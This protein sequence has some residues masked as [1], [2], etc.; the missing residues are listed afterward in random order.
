MFFGTIVAP[1]LTQIFVV[2]LPVRSLPV[3]FLT[4]AVAIPYRLTFGT[5]VRR[6]GFATVET[7]SLFSVHAYDLF[8]Q[9][10][11]KVFIEWHGG[12]DLI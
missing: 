11:I 4:V 3:S 5:A 10:F 9:V 12:F 8:A 2:C 6:S 1:Y 7:T